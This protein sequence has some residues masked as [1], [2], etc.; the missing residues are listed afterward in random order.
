MSSAQNLSISRDG[1]RL[2]CTVGKMAMDEYNDSDSWSVL[3]HV[4]DNRGENGFDLFELTEEERAELANAFKDDSESGD[5][6]DD[7]NQPLVL[8]AQPHF[9]WTGG[10]TAVTWDIPLIFSADVYIDIVNIVVQSYGAN[11]VHYIY[12]RDGAWITL[13]WNNHT[14]NSYSYS[15]ANRHLF[16]TISR[17]QTMWQTEFLETVSMW[18][19]SETSD[20]K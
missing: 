6:L 20:C 17:T 2:F 15:C 13:K 1:V 19:L 7:E 8:P 9:E 14:V 12:D 18:M 10:D 3:W 5:E 16:I 4:Y 11:I